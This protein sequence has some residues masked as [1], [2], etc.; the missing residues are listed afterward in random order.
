MNILKKLSDICKRFNENGVKYVIVGG[1][2]VI[3]HGLPRTTQD[4]DIIIEI[5][6]ENIE[7][8]KNALKGLVSSGLD[9]LTYELVENYVT[10]KGVIRIGTDEG[11]YIDLIPKI[12]EITYEKVIKNAEKE[13]IDDTIIIYAGLDD[14]IESKK[15]IRA[16]DEKDRIFLM[17]KKRFQSRT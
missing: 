10:K 12:G 1:C 13:L 6:Q 9:E 7:R 8:I 14:L 2:A 5:S 15:T 17:G 11:F 3:L 4:I 16:Q